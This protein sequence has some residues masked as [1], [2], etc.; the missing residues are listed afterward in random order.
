MCLC[1]FLY[2]DT[3]ATSQRAFG[4][5]RPRGQ[6]ALWTGYSTQGGAVKGPDIAERTDGT[7]LHHSGDGF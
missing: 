2:I 5:M 7:A 4:T 3:H 6:L 1:V